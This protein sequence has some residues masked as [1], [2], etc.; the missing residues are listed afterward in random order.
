[1]ERYIKQNATK[2]RRQSSV[3]ETKLWT[4]TVGKI[5]T[6]EEPPKS[7]GMKMVQKAHNRLLRV[8]T[9]PRLKDRICIERMLEKT[10][11][12]SVNKISV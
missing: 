5:K 4:T 9:M 7:S 12:L 6:S 10:N 11:T 3:F 2:S 8:L 1:M